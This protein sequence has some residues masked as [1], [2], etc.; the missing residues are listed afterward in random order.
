MIF[1]DLSYIAQPNLRI[2]F[3]KFWQND[4]EKMRVCEDFR[5]IVCQNLSI[6]AWKTIPA[7]LTTRTLA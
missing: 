7:T 1:A 3:G 6:D 2:P 5:N 4:F